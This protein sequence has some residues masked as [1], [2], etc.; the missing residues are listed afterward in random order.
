MWESTQLYLIKQELRH[1]FGPTWWGP[2]RTAH[3]TRFK[4][5]CIVWASVGSKA[6]DMDWPKHAPP[7]RG[8]LMWQEAKTHVQAT[9]NTC[10]SVCILIHEQCQ[11]TGYLIRCKKYKSPPKVTNP[12]SLALVLDSQKCPLK[13]TNQKALCLSLCLSLN[14]KEISRIMLSR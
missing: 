4:S 9:H 1:L 13:A 8:L 6:G 11:K 5:H 10:N 12:R 3:Y 7:I 14:R 2:L